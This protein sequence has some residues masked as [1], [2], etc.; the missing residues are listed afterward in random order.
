MAGAEPIAGATVAAAYGR[1]RERFGPSVRRLQRVGNAARRAQP[2]SLPAASGDAVS[3]RSADGASGV[4]FAATASSD[5]PCEFSG[6][7]CHRHAA[8]TRLHRR[9][10]RRAAHRRPPRGSRMRGIARCAPAPRFVD[11]ASAGFAETLREFGRSGPPTGTFARS[12]TVAGSVSG[13]VVAGKGLTAAPGGA[14][15]AAAGPG[16]LNAVAMSC[17]AA[18][19]PAAGVA[20]SD[21]M[22]GN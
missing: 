15:T 13:V 18:S 16:T 9:A 10:R 14:A 21:P 3:A 22:G 2:R 7:R 11:W 1:T 4:A 8:A 6:R 20:L 19:A 12:W 17:V 5:S